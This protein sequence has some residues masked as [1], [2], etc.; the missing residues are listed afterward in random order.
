MFRQRVDENTSLKMLELRDADEL[1]ALLDASRSH[2]RTWLPFVDGTRTVQDIQ[3]F[4]QSG[5]QQFANSNG[6]QLGIWHHGQLAGVL[7]LHYIQWTHRMTS[8]GY[9]LGEG[10]QGKGIM[11][12]AC[13]ALIDFLFQE[14]GLNRVEIRVAPDNLKSRAIPER[15]GF[16]QE[17]CRRQAEWLYDH[18]VDHVLYGMLAQDWVHA[19]R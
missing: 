9:W 7:G 12:N 18:Y 2:L 13:R 11:T 6:V 17:G 10:F 4:I 14:Y 1:F 8:L 5:L 16:Q 3:D 19:S 15:L